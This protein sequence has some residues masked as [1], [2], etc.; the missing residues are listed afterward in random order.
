M[1]TKSGLEIV[2]ELLMLV[3]VISIHR[4]KFLRGHN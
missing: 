3:I 1:A 2:D 4:V